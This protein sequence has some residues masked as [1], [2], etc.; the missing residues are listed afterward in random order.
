MTWREKALLFLTGLAI[1]AVLFGAALVIGVL[2]W[3]S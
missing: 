2:L 3:I 1:M